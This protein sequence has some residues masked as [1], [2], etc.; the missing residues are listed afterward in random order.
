MESTINVY[1]FSVLCPLLSVTTTSIEYVLLSVS[2]GT[3][4]SS[5]F[6]VFKL[7]SL[8]VKTVLPSIVALTE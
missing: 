7:S 2:I 3:V 4:I 5:I 8:L 1:V 6:F